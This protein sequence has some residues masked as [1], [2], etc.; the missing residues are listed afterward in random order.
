MTSQRISDIPHPAF[1]R[2]LPKKSNTASENF[3][4]GRGEDRSLLFKKT[5]IFA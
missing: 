1:G 2:P 4:M 3:I 5:L